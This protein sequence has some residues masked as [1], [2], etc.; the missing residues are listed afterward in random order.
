MQNRLANI[1]NLPRRKQKRVDQEHHGQQHNHIP[2]PVGPQPGQR[3]IAP[4]LSQLALELG[5]LA[6][7]LGVR[8]QQ[9]AHGL[10]RLDVPMFDHVVD[11]AVQMLRLR[12]AATVVFCQGRAS[13]VAVRPGE[14]GHRE[15]LARREYGV[16]DFHVAAAAGGSDGALEVTGRA[17]AVVDPE[18][19]GGAVAVGRR[20]FPGAQLGLAAGSGRRHPV[21]RQ[22]NRRQHAAAVGGRAVRRRRAGPDRQNWAGPDRRFDGVQARIAHIFR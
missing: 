13:G 20:V 11:F 7:Q 8:Q 15:L 9:Q 19:A 22:R 12:H 16:V 2:P 3:R 5:H 10:S 17:A 21:G 1:S 6:Q 18:M 14:V 4:Q